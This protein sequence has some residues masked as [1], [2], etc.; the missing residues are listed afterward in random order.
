MSGRSGDPLGQ[1][2]FARSVFRF[3]LNLS[4]SRFSRESQLRFYSLSY[5]K[6]APIK[7]LMIGRA[8]V[9]SRKSRVVYSDYFVF[10]SS[11]EPP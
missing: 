11:R 4:V 9:S 2:N 5:S 8:K 1:S 6:K 3:F 10:R 7:V